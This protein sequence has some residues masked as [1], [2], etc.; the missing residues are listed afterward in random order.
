MTPVELRL[1]ADAAID[2]GDTLVGMRIRP[3]AAPLR[4][5]FSTLGHARVVM[6]CTPDRRGADCITD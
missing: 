3:V 4:P 1:K 5:E 6:A 2:V